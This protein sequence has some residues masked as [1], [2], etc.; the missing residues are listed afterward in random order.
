MVKTAVYHAQTS[1]STLTK[2]LMESVFVHKC[3]FISNGVLLWPFGAIDKVLF[4]L[5]LSG[6]FK[7]H[8]VLFLK[9]KEVT[10]LSCE[11]SVSPT[12]S[13]IDVS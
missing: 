6:I 11:A 3:K 8:Q 2:F 7:L 9:K 12:V 4:G 10:Q 13:T 5:Y 1:F